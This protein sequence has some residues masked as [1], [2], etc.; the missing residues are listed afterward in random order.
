[1]AEQFK[2]CVPYTDRI[3]G[4]L[5]DNDSGLCMGIASDEMKLKYAPN[6]VFNQMIAG[7]PHKLVYHPVG[8]DT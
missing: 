3:A 7:C 6:E 5:Y 8:F 1:M 4:Y 2:V